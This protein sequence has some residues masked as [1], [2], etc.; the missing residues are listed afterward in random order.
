MEIIKE[1]S[2]NDIIV[3][4]SYDSDYGSTCSRDK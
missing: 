3:N 2:S 1:A 4:C